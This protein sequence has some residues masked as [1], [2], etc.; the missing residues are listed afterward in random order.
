[1]NTQGDM[2]KTLCHPDFKVK[3]DNDNPLDTVSCIVWNI[4][5][6][7]Q[8]LYNMMS[9]VYSDGEDFYEDDYDYYD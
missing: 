4:Y 8:D 2:Q 3:N 1:M 7:Q 6:Q 5:N 9:E